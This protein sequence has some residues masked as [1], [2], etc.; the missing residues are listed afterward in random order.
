[1]LGAF[2][3]QWDKFAGAL[4]AVGRR[5]D[6]VQ[7]AYDDLAGTRKRA[8]ERPLARL[9]SLRTDRG[10]RRRRA[11]PARRRRRVVRRRP[12]RARG[13]TAGRDRAR[14]PPGRARFYGGAMALLDYLRGEIVEDYADGVFSRRE[15]LRRLVLLGVSRAGGG[16]PAGRLR[17]RRQRHRRPPTRHLAVAAPRR[18]DAGVHLGRGDRPRRRPP[19]PPTTGA[20]R[21]PPPAPTPAVP[22]E[23]ITFA[24][25]AGTLQGWYAR[26][27]GPDGRRP[28]HPREPGPHAPLPAAARAGSRPAATARCRSTCCRG[29]AAPPPS[30]TRP[31]PRPPS[32]RPPRSAWSRTCAP[33]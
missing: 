30:P 31:R 5:I 16:R 18:R 27:A 23:A 1:M 29:R 11:L 6:S 8:L 21:R 3:Q 19:P 14:P 7:K 10:H 13:V 12:R 26:R 25:P 17:R 32:A 28:H 33:G 15:A 4:D 22:S 2:E 9:S 20:A 24:G